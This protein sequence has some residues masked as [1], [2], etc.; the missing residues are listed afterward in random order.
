MGRRRARGAPLPKPFDDAFKLIDVLE[1]NVADA[2]VEAHFTGE[3]VVRWMFD[4]IMV[5][6][7]KAAFPITR[8][9][10][11]TS[12]LHETMTLPV[13]FPAV[14]CTFTVKV[15]SPEI[16]ML[17]PAPGLVAIKEDRGVHIMETVRAAYEI[18]ERF[19]KVRK[20]TRWL[21]MFATIGAARHYCPWL[22]SVLPADHPFQEASGQIY[23]EPA[24]SMA[25]I[26]PTMRECGAIMASA[27]LCHSAD[28]KPDKGL[29]AVTFRGQ[30]E[31]TD[32]AA[33]YTSNSFG[34]L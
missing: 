20:V 16:A 31:F 8:D 6:K 5:D 15:K 13:V 29:V 1:Q 32:A 3:Q 22:T 9:Q 27:L 34:L 25:E 12:F 2:S 4:D 10:D 7:L 28:G 11:R 19:E 21:N 14:S 30:R 24:K 17:V 18:H 23:R 26:T 33:E